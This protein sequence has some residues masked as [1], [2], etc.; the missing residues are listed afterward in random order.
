MNRRFFAKTVS[1]SAIGFGFLGFRNKQE[2]SV[3][4]LLGINEPLLFGEAFLLRKEAAE[5]FMTMQ[6]DAAKAGFQLYSESSYRSYQRQEEIWTGKYQRFIN[7]GLAPMDA[8]R[9]IIEYSTIPGTSRHHWGTEVDIIDKSRERP[10]DP[11]LR[12]HFEKGGVYEELKTWLDENKEK[13]GFYE[14][15]S[16]QYGRRGFHYEPWHLSY[17]AISQPI[18][19]EFLGLNLKVVLQQKHLI[20]SEHF[21]NDFIL[22]YINEN[23]LDINPVLL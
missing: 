12:E 1:L 3:E 13:Y 21:T 8:I 9:K 7:E 23:M 2:F 6:V 14:V 22:Q 18:L 5:A 11:L 19:R 10:E 16:S 20:G 15:Y 4:E 17:K